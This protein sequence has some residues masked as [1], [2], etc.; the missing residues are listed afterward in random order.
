MH[1]RIST[2]TRPNDPTINSFLPRFYFLYP[3]IIYFWQ[4]IF[5]KFYLL[6]RYKNRMYDYLWW[7]WFYWGCRS[8]WS[9]YMR[10]VSS[11]FKGW[12]CWVKWSSC[13]LITASNNTNSTVISFAS[14]ISQ[15]WDNSTNILNEWFWHNYVF[16]ALNTMFYIILY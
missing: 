9:K 15:Y 5:A 7:I 2:K 10:K 3:L 12:Y 14:V 4:I 16:F 6:W 13:E 1:V 11:C 8:F